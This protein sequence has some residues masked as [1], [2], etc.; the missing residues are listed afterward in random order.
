MLSKAIVC[1]LFHSHKADIN[2]G[3]PMKIDLCVMKQDGKESISFMS[4][5]IGMMADLD[6][7]TEYMRWMGGTRFMVGFFLARGFSYSQPLSFVHWSIV[8]A[9]RSCPMKLEVK[10]ASKDKQQMVATYKEFRQR[11]H[12]QFDDCGSF[13]VDTDNEEWTAIDKQLAYVW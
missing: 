5:S 6:L 10:I 3:K 1:A 2:I 4:Q 13:S 11:T 7:G 8:F 9:N 12:G